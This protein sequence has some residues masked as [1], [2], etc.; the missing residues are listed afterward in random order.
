L[1]KTSR[2]PRP[3]K[4]EQR[5]HVDRFLD[6]IRDELPADVDLTVE[7]IVDRVHGID[8]RIRKML[9]ETLDQQGLSIGDWKVLNTL[10]W[11]GK[12]YRRS[13]GELAKRADLTSGAMTSRLDQLEEEGLVRRLRDPEDRRG[14]LVELTEQGRKRHEEAFGV[15]AQKEALLGEALGERELEQLNAL[16]RR[17]MLSLEERFPKM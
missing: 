10:R 14:V 13:A 11:A 2:V 3:R 15:Q 6:E 4:S 5:D 12:P 1:V 7:G 17:V 9:D 8:W 16:L